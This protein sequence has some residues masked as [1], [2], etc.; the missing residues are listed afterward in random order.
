MSSTYSNGRYL[1]RIQAQGFERSTAKGTPCFYLQLLILSRYG[2]D[3]KLQDCPNYERTYRQYLANDIGVNI[4]R[5]DLK[6]LGVEVTDLAQL[7]PS[8]RQDYINL[9]GREI[10]VF[11]KFEQY[12]G[13]DQ[14]RWSIARTRELLKSEDLRAL[15]DSFGHLLRADSGTTATTTIPV[16]PD[17]T[18]TPF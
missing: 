6:T 10:D 4:L 1:A 15:N 18:S 3:G 11:C 7:Q 5:S 12:L 16:V 17:T 9:S 2:V 8:T 14:E 13:R